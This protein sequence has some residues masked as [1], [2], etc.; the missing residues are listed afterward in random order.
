MTKEFNND[1]KIAV[2]NSMLFMGIADALAGYFGP[3]H[4]YGTLGKAFDMEKLTAATTTPITEMKRAGVGDK[5]ME[6]VLM[7]ILIE[8][9]PDALLPVPEQG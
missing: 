9:F 4:L 8:A 3:A 2:R 5:D 7:F 1:H 6:A